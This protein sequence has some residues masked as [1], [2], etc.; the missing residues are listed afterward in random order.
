MNAIQPARVGKGVAPCRWATTPLDLPLMRFAR[1]GERILARSALE[2]SSGT[3]HFWLIDE[4]H[5]RVND[6]QWSLR[7]EPDF[8]LMTISR[9]RSDGVRRE[10]GYARQFA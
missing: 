10:I 8:R 7:I 6:L 2:F 9:S 1:G 4:R 3:V 5:A